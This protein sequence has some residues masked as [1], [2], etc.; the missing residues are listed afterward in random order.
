MNKLK[1]KEEIEDSSQQVETK[2]ILSQIL[3]DVGMDENAQKGSG[4]NAMG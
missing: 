4:D 1:P 3:F 2:N